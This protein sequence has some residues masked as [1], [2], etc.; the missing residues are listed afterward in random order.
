ME[1]NKLLHA[2]ECFIIRINTILSGCHFASMLWRIKCTNT[3]IHSH[4]LTKYETWVKHAYSLQRLR[5][6]QQQQQQWTATVVMMW[7]WYQ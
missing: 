1:S 2:I 7:W 4:Q 5:W 3:G 6:K